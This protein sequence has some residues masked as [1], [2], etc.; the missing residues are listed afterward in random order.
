MG[1]AQ[2]FRHLPTPVRSG[3]GEAPVHVRRW[4]RGLL[5]APTGKPVRGVFSVHK[6]RK[7][8]APEATGGVPDLPLG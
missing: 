3:G 5:L 8:R 2:C 6:L 1:E 7:W 4:A